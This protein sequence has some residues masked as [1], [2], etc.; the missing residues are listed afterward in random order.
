MISSIDRSGGVLLEILLKCC[1]LVISPN[2]ISSRSP[3]LSN[4]KSQYVKLDF[5]IPFWLK[6]AS[7]YNRISHTASF[8]VEN[9]QYHD[10][11]CVSSLSVVVPPAIIPFVGFV[12]FGKRRYDSHRERNTG[13]CSILGRSNW[14]TIW[15]I[16]KEIQYFSP[17]SCLAQWPPLS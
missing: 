6:A 1:S 13:H 7:P 9:F 15:I 12:G 10:S 16:C 3:T 11:F 2:G 4:L 8:K 17:P 5:V 14:P